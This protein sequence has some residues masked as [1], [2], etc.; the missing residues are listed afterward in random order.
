MAL[1]FCVFV[2]VAST[3]EQENASYIGELGKTWVSFRDVRDVLMCVNLYKFLGV[4]T[5]FF[6]LSA[7]TMGLKELYSSF[8]YLAWRL[9]WGGLTLM[10]LE[11]E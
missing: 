10:L 8:S 6:A 2:S 5:T 1:L 9:G 4:K 3:H 7:I 11:R